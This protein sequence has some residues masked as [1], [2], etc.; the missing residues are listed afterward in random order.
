MVAPSYTPA[1]IYGGPTRAVTDLC[2]NLAKA[3]H[4]VNV[5]TTDAN[6]QNNLVIPIGQELIING[7]QVRYHHRWTKDHTHLTPSLL[8]RVIRN[9]RKYDVVHL[10][11]WW[12]LVTLPVVFICILRGIRPV[13]SIRG[14]LSDYSFKHRRYLIKKLF[15]DTVGKWML[16]HAILHV[17]SD[18]EAEEVKAVVPHSYLYVIPNFIK[19]PSPP[20]GIRAMEKSF[21]QLLFVGRIDAVKNIEFLIE[22]LNEEWDIPIQLNIIG[23]G[24]DEYTASL[25][26]KSKHNQRIAWLGNLDGEAKWN[27]LAN[28][29]LLVLPS[30]TENF[31][32]VVI[33][34][35]S[36]GTPVLIS[37]QVGLKEYVIQNQLGWVAKTEMQ[38]WKKLLHAIWSDLSERKRIHIEAPVR[39]KTDFNEKKLVEKYIDVYQQAANFVK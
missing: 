18:K 11:S 17:T 14:T 31:G 26:Q 24:D 28:A 39:I 36:Q 1:F 6:G 12:N 10:T 21:F 20:P 23:E 8:F 2:E 15:Q 38:E 33:E 9:V 16:S 34:A 27:Y 5:Y 13:L 37:D 32:N 29:D 19:F 4:Q 35:L 22:L 30:K 3:G 25:Q 7:V